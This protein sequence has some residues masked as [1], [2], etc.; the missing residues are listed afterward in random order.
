M[1]DF[2]ALPLVLPRHELYALADAERRRREQAWRAH[3]ARDETNRA[4]ADK[5]V[6]LWRAIVALLGHDTLPPDIAPLIATARTTSQKFLS[7]CPADPRDID[8][9]LHGWRMTTIAR[10]LESYA[11]TLATSVAAQAAMH[12]SMAA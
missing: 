1:T 9:E 2:A 11:G 5:D 6:A 3:I 4:R 10:W 12:R 8:A 7:A